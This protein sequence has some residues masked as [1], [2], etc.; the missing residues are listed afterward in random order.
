[1]RVQQ[2]I[3]QIFYFILFFIFLN[4][5]SSFSQKLSGIVTPAPSR[6][7]IYQNQ[8]L[9]RRIYTKEDGIFTISDLPFGTYDLFAYHG[10]EYNF[11][12][13]TIELSLQKPEQELKINLTLMLNMNE[14]GWYS[15]DAHLHSRMSDG[16]Q[17]FPEVA[18]SAKAEG[19]NFLIPTEHNWGAKNTLKHLAKKQNEYNTKN[20]QI[21]AGEEVGPNAINV[22]YGHFGALMIK[23]FI[24]EFVP[25]YF[26]DKFSAQK[27]LEEVHKQ[28]GLV[29][30]NHPYSGFSDKQK[31]ES[32]F[33]ALEN[34]NIPYLIEGFD[35]VEALRSEESLLYWYYLLNKGYKPFIIGNTD[36]HD[37]YLRPLGSVRTYIYIGENKL[38]QEAIYTGFKKGNCFATEGPLVFFKVSWQNQ[39]A[40][41]GE[42]LKINK[43]EEVTFHLEAKSIFPLQKIILIKNGFPAEEWNIN[44]NEFLLDYKLKIFLE[45]WYALKVLTTE[46]K[47]AHTNPIWI[48]F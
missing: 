42:T 7:D 30:I 10:F 26:P 14:L 4:I 44:G 32:Y 38:S 18:A 41:L 2:K 3:K 40:S 24:K 20:F 19:L 48:K 23:E 45:G 8:K 9:V 47:I 27:I 11:F 13:Q 35:G 39:K 5:V 33:W 37:I 21:Y 36:S 31:S 1:V 46:N 34:T 16:A 12:K 22:G 43:G 29:V 28:N 17:Y 25:G 15:G 6:I